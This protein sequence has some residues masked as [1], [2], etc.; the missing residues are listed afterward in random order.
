MARTSNAATLAALKSE[1]RRSIKW[2]KDD[3]YDGLWRRMIDLYRGRHYDKVLKTDRIVVNMAFATINVIAPSVAVNN[4]KITINA[5]HPD[6]APHAII[7][8]EAINYEWRVN[9]F[10]T[11]FRS[12][13]NDKLITG[14][15]WLKVGWKYVAT[16]V[17][18][19]AV[20][21]QED[22]QAEVPVQG[23]EQ[24]DD[25]SVE[26]N[27]IV[28]EDRPILERVSQFDIF[29]DP[30]AHNP[31]ELR[32]IA[33]R[34]RRAIGDAKRDRTYSAK[35]RR[36]LQPTMGSKWGPAEEHP[37]AGTAPD[38]EKSGY[39]EVW[40]FWDI[41]RYTVQTF[42]MEGDDF[43]RAPKRSPYP[44]CHPFYMLRNYEVPD[45]FYPMGELEAVE[46]LQHELNQTRTQMLNHRK[47]FSRKWL[48]KKSAFADKEA[49][50]QLESDIDNTMVGIDT[51]EP[52][53]NVIAP[54]PA[55]ISPPEF[56]NQSSLIRDDI[57]L[58]TAV[59][60]YSHGGMPDMKRTATEAAMIQDASNARAADKLSKIEHELADVAEM[61][62]KVMQTFLTGE[63]VVRIVGVDGAPAWFTYDLDYIKGSFDFEVEA[64]STQP[65]NETFRRQSGLQMVDALA[66]FAAVLNLPVLAQYVMEECFGVKNAQRFIMAPQPPPQVG[67]PEQPG[68]NPEAPGVPEQPGEP[69][70]P[71]G[72][73]QMDPAAMAAQMQA[74]Q[75]P[76]S[77]PP[78]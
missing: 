30:D 16:D 77:G 18:V 70:D 69:A 7:A 32:W 59:S 8:E 28:E 48:Y 49:V 39:V 66:P 64:G 76:V 43:L 67:G 10:Q 20:E 73:P 17:D 6:H 61:L 27:Q 25:P 35:A 26:V 52:I 72:G 12:A 68:E 36:D 42:T 71:Q 47:K 78:A 56:Y 45:E 53:G 54:L 14:H 40:E 29:V 55:V 60:E 2:R 22:G 19:P 1:L 4:P 3:D 23:A 21:D 41:K 15:G 34:V 11:E 75:A 5:R 65:R 31:K 44:F 37:Q 38:A 63:K 33:Q 62:L 51:D 57:N 58:V 46:E 13:T 24:P 9:K 50:E 74:M